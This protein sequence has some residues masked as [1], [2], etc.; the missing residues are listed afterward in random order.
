MADFDAKDG[1]LYQQEARI[2]FLRLFEQ[3]VPN[4]KK[5]LIDKPFRY[6]EADEKV[7]EYANEAI[8]SPPEDFTLIEDCFS[9]ENVRNFLLFYESF[10]E[11]IKAYNFNAK[12]LEMHLINLFESWH[13]KPSLDKYLFFPS[14][15]NA[16]FIVGDHWKMKNGKTMRFEFSFPAFRFNEIRENEYKTEIA[17]A[18]Q[19]QLN[20]YLIEVK[21]FA[22]ANYK[23]NPKP[24]KLEEHIEWFILYQVERKTYREIAEKYPDKKGIDE[25][26]II[27]AAH[28]VAELLGITLREGSKRGRKRKT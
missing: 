11:W 16:F 26:A 2:L 7:R 5:E 17:K 3:L 13:L 14:P 23:K 8:F 20:E 6:Y 10:R 1:G 19:Q 15:M 22:G 18:F 4:A 9:K 25:A 28:N 12:W 27:Q 21:T 24:R